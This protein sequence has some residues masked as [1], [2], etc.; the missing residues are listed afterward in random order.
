MNK[1]EEKLV[2][3]DTIEVPEEVLAAM[4]GLPEEEPKEPKEPEKRSAEAETEE[5]DRGD[6]D[7]AE[8]KP[9]PEK[10]EAKH[11]PEYYKAKGIKT[12]EHIKDLTTRRYESDQR[13]DRAEAENADLKQRLVEAEAARGAPKDDPRIRQLDEAIDL[14]REDGSDFVVDALKEQREKLLA[15]ETRAPAQPQYQQQPQID[16]S[17]Q[18]WMK[19]NQ[20]FQEADELGRQRYPQLAREAQQRESVLRQTMPVGPELYQR[21]DEEMAFTL[22]AW[23]LTTRPTGGNG[24]EPPKEAQKEPPR[25]GLQPSRTGGAEGVDQKRKDGLTAEE[26]RRMVFVARQTGKDH[27]DPAYR[28]AFIRQIRG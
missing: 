15:G 27:N 11:N 7:A 8:E 1:V 13:A 17:A 22:D 18:A 9:H 24:S 14:A 6:E 2:E 25:A 28:K 4:G 12:R 16:P 19:E 20:W 26:H 3:A 5:Q 10:W 21:L 23:G